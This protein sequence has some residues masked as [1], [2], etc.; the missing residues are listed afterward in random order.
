MKCLGTRQG[1]KLLVLAH[2]FMLAMLRKNFMVAEV[3]GKG[4]LSTSAE[5]SREENKRSR[6]EI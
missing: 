6:N 3:C 2:S 5:R 1:V 4:N